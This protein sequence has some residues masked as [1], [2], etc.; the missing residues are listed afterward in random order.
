M[1]KIL[2]ITDTY[3]PDSRA[4]IAIVQRMA[5]TLVKQGYSVSVLPINVE[6]KTKF[7]YLNSYQGVKID[8]YKPFLNLSEKKFGFFDNLNNFAY[9]IAL[10]PK[11]FL[12]NSPQSEKWNNII[13]S[14]VRYIR[15]HIYEKPRK[16]LYLLK[17][18]TAIK[19]YLMKKEFDTVI[20]ISLPFEVNLCT[21][22]ALTSFKM[23]KWI[24]ICFDPYAYDETI[25]ERECKR[26]IKL[27]KKVYKNAEKVMM[28]SQ[29]KQDYIHNQLLRKL[30]FF[31]LPNIRKMDVESANM[32]FELDCN[33][34]NCIFLGNLYKLQRH[35]EFTFQLF[36][37][38][39]N[40]KIRLYIVG[41]LVDIEKNYIDEWV[42][43]EKGKF[44][45][46]DRISQ[47]EATS[48]M[49]AADVLI[50]IG[51]VTQNQCPS[52]LIDYIS[53]GKPILNISKI[54]KCTS[55]PYLSVYPNKYIIREGKSIS[56]EE[57]N[58][59]E[60]FLLSCKG[61]KRIKYESIRDLYRECTMEMFCKRIEQMVAFG[62]DK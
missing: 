18:S 12:I 59:L 50:N 32:P 52:K 46:H 20:S 24:P 8:N 56:K 9:R 58:A 29:F 25:N 16:R 62:G 2:I 21:G 22:T 35:P 38:I 55:I 14:I 13:M 6:S 5:E 53:T 1:N 17:H 49:D 45:Y 60:M 36:K 57:I 41:G 26:R 61:K 19:E 54:D 23:K 34:V 4:T 11:R 30:D 31:E 10:F 39:N 43:R 44:F 51:N 7:D 47:N 37:L 40:E 15:K 33:F 48:L 3:Y 27:E 42:N 28:L